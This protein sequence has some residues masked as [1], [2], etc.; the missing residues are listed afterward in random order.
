MLQLLI[1]P[2]PENSRGEHNPAARVRAQPDGRG[3]EAGAVEGALGR[4]QGEEAP[5]LLRHGIPRYVS[6]MKPRL[7]N[8]SHKPKISCR[9]WLNLVMS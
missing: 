4:H 5:L 7:L 2:L 1:S 3:P 9:K 6:G 8:K